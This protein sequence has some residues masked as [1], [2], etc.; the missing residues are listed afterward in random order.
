[1]YVLF[2][3][4]LLKILKIYSA[5]MHDHRPGPVSG[6]SPPGRATGIPARETAGPDRDSR[7]DP[8]RN[9][10]LHYVLRINWPET[11]SVVIW[12]PGGNEF[13]TGIDRDAGKLHWFQWRQSFEVSVTCHVKRTHSSYSEQIKTSNT[14]Y[15]SAPPI[16]LYDG[17]LRFCRFEIQVKGLPCFI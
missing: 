4:F 6:F 3:L 1:M 7:S 10:Q 8:N 13:G 12:R 11:D 17:H 16:C 14:H 5:P 9:V 2:F 15:E